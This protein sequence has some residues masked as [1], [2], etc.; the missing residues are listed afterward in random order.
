MNNTFK[1]RFT[2]MVTGIILS[3]IFFTSLDFAYGQSIYGPSTILNN[4]NI[5]VADGCIKFYHTNGYY[6]DTDKDKVAVM[7]QRSIWWE[8]Q[9]VDVTCKGWRDVVKYFLDNG[10]KIEGEGLYRITMFK[11][12]DQ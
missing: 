12:S 5:T 1:S 4:S 3:G 10:Y 6:N 9:L 7:K 11:L 2:I 8:G